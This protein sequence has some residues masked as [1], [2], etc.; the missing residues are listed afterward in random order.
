MGYRSRFFL[1]SSGY[2]CNSH[3][4]YNLKGFTSW[5]L[6]RDFSF[7]PVDILVI[8]INYNIKG[9]YIIGLRSSSFLYSR[10]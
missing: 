4:N 8:I 10:R 7:T 9:F 3:Y 5:E 6:G 2:S 1:N